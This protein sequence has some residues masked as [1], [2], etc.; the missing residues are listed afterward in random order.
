MTTPANVN[1]TS[2]EFKANPYPFYARLRAEEPVIRVPIP[3]KQFVWLITRYDDVAAALKDER[4]V[5]NRR[6]AREQDQLAKEPW[7]PAFAKAMDSNMLDLDA[8]DHTRLRGLVHKA[9]TPKIIEEMRGRVQSITDELLDAA[10]AR[11][12]MDLIRDFALPLPVT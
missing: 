7:M 3:G 5:K 4:F 11:G 9:F 8:P 10:Q 1:I 12:Q 2:P 6:N